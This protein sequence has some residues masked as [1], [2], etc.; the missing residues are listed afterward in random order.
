MLRMLQGLPTI[1]AYGAQA[2]FRAQFTDALDANGAWWF[3]FISTARWVGFRLDLIASVILTAGCIL[4]MDIY[5]RVRLGCL[6]YP[7]HG[8]LPAGVP[9]VPTLPCAWPS[10][11]GC[12]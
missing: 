8:H 7:V 10:T 6:P 2:R 12:A 5:Q 11:S 4:C 9:R 3:A 1:R